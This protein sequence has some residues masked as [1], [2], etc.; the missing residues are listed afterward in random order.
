MGAITMKNNPNT[1]MLTPLNISIGALALIVIFLVVMTP[2]LYRSGS[3][4]LVG[5][6]EPDDS[7][8]KLLA[9]HQT[10]MGTDVERFTG[11]S[12]FYTPEIKR[13]PPP[14]PPPPPPKT[15]EDDKPPPP[16]PPPKF[17]P[18]YTGPKLV[19]ILGDEAWFKKQ[20]TD[21]DP[22][23]RLKIGETHD[24]IDVVSTDPPR[25]ITVNYQGGGP[26]EVAL[27]DMD[28]TPF[29]DMPEEI[30]MPTGVLEDVHEDEH[31][32]MDEPCP[33]KIEGVDTPF[34][35]HPG[36]DDSES[37]IE[38][39]EPDEAE[40]GSDAIEPDE[41]EAGTE[42]PPLEPSKDDLGTPDSPSAPTPVPS[43]TED[44]K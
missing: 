11:R 23:T 42:A 1:S 37:G 41:V 9:R 40:P 2:S 43:D 17:P 16:P 13:K 6:P 24:D 27:I 8:D 39:I 20:A 14:P 21:G 35:Q 32:H 29:A 26:Y 4:I 15:E 12:F 30:R 36:V 19:A 18:N 28:S 31:E 3:T 22:L 34:D 44:L 38:V 5:A 25:G 33:P 10:N 7:M